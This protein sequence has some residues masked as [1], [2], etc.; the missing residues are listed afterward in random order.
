MSVNQIDVN[1]VNARTE[2]EKVAGVEI[3]V[4][5]LPVVEGKKATVRI[6]MAPG[7]SA[8]VSCEGWYDVR[9]AKVLFMFSFA[10][11][12]VFCSPTPTGVGV[13]NRIK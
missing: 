5:D 6:H 3:P 10:E 11:L 1:A 2:A 13:R 8:C 4:I 12:F 9:T 7:D